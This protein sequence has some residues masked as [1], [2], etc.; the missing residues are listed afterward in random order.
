MRGVA[1]GGGE[2]GGS[3]TRVFTL[4]GY[5]VIAVA[6]LAS[7]LRARRRGNATLADAVTLIMRN[8]VGRA[9]VLIAWL[10]LGW[11]LFVRVGNH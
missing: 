6:A 10:W 8:R 1:A 3:M 9:F 4:A 11:H 2:A 5:A 7:E